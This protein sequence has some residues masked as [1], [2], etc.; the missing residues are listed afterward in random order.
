MP[1]LALNCQTHAYRRRDPEK[2]VLYQAVAENLETFLERLRT[3][4]HELPKYVVEEFYRYLDCG[5]LARGF[6]R[7]ACESCGKSF[8]VPFSCKGRA[9][10]SSCMGRRMADTAAHLVDNV[11]PEVP[12]RQWVLSLPIEIRYRMSYDKRLISDVLA[13][14]L[15]VVQGWYRRKA[16][17]LGFANLQGGS[18]SFLQKFG[19]SLNAT[20]HYHCLVLD[21]AYTFPDDAN[22]PFF[23]ATPPPTDEDVKQIAETVAARAIRLL[24][25][26]GVIGEQDLYD[27]FSDENPLLAGM[28]AAS[29]RGMIA[30]GERAGLP[31]RRVLSDPARGVR[32]SRLC[33]VSRGFSLHAARRIEAHDR[34]GLEQLCSYV[35]RPPLAAGSLEKVGDDKY[36]FKMKSSWSD[37]TVYIILS[38]H[39][40]LEKLSS[41]VPPPRSHTTR[42]HGIL[43]PNSALRAKVV[44]AKSNGNEPSEERK[45]SG[46]TKYRLAWAALLSRVFQIDVS[47][48]P[49]CQGKMKIIAF[50]T[51]PASVQRYLRGEG[52]P[53]EAPPIAPA[54][55]PPQMEFDL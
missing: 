7:C 50:I 19:S 21:G 2:E 39:E 14:F 6:A 4:G 49:A 45:N 20:P 55:S 9:F 34:K 22:E 18:V 35:T 8:A 24:E 52:L 25:R 40:L 28:T 17:E 42:Y 11:F 3:E 48:C 30:T 13:V 26:R 38:G 29:V 44:P 10:C 32:T 23:V 43:A 5:I 41:I 16:E 51:D 37:G 53:T 31:V 36:R 54:R 15:R 12:V 33:Y 27:P 46:S 47:V 1:S